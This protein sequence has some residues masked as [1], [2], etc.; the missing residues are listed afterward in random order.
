MLSFAWHVNIHDT[1]VKI[2]TVISVWPPRCAVTRTWL[3]ITGIEVR[4][5]LWT[6]AHIQNLN[7]A[8]SK[9]YTGMFTIFK[10]EKNIAHSALW[11]TNLGVVALILSRIRWATNNISP[12]GIR[13]GWFVQ[14]QSIFIV[15][16]ESY[17]TNAPLKACQ[18]DAGCN[19]RT[20]G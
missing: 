7:T 1:L 2:F 20:N 18:L 5:S 17:I 10:Q 16:R 12:N 15:V 8:S 6:L 3:T 9:K 4:L 19:A 13:S 11:S 14:G